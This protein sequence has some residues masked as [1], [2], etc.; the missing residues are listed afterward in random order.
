MLCWKDTLAAAF[1]GV[2]SATLAR[3]TGASSY[4]GIVSMEGRWLVR[5]TIRER[6]EAEPLERIGICPSDPTSEE[7]STTPASS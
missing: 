5:L 7:E 3:G 4:S 2:G 1:A 6:I